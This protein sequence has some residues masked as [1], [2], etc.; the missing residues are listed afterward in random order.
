[1]IETYPNLHQD[2][3]EISIAGRLPK[4]LGNKSLLTQCFSNLLGNAIKF[5]APGVKPRVRIWQ[6]TLSQ[7]EPAQ[8][9]VRIWVEDNGVG[10][11]KEVQGRVFQ[12]FQRVHV[13]YPGT[14]IGLAIVWKVVDRMGGSVG[15][16]SE[17]GRGSKFWV[18]LPSANA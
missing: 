13:E 6:E 4:V 2:I 8:G 3:A 1:L 9:C 5:V 15:V 16:E 11:P 18:I 12:I 17:P 10:I 14:G 7:N